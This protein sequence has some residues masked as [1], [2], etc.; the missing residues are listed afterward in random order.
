MQ[1]PMHVGDIGTAVMLDLGEDIG[2]TLAQHIKV[3]KANG[4]KVVWAATVQG[5][6]LIHYTQMNDLNV[7]GTY[8]MQGYVKT[9]IWE[10]HGRMEAVEV[11]P[12]I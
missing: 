7:E 10:G 4:Q 11:L 2:V 12:V 6:F 8:Q 5:Q 9:A 1:G 3:T